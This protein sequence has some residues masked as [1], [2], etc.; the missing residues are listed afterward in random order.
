[1]TDTKII[2]L[3]LPQFHR[4]P[5]NDEFWGEGFTDW[6]SVKNAKPLYEGHNQPR[7]PLNNNYYDLS[8]KENVAWQAKL[9]RKYGIYG[10]GVYHY[11]F[12]NNQNLLT[13]PAEIMRDNDDID[14]NYCF[15][16]DNISWKRTWSNVEGNDWAPIYDNISSD[17]KSK[18]LVSYI[19][20]DKKDWEKHYQW[21]LPFFK[22][23]RYIKLKN[24]LVYVIFHYSAEVKE[25]CKY[26]DSLAKK[27][28]FDGF[29]FIFRYD[30]TEKIPINENILTYEPAYGGWQIESLLGIIK[31]RLKRIFINKGILKVDYDNTWEK[32]ISLANKN[33]S[34]NIIHGAFV[35]FDDSPRRGFKARIVENSTPEKFAKY[36]SDLLSI[37]RS[38]NKEFIFLSAWNEWGEGMMLEPDTINGYAY[39][40][41]IKNSIEKTIKNENF[42]QPK[43]YTTS[44][45]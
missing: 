4:I 31:R 12:N 35:S 5:E 19:L 41:A 32:I 2:A 44:K 36:F 33:N 8:Q 45:R 30:K 26:W 23:K 43:S 42:I 20:G 10:F 1:M 6:V 27:D 40:E 17:N 14:I 37:S 38:Q 29:E 3:Y 9:A 39:L 13:S 25:M 11:W 7:V 21:L 18:Y 34:K 24:K 15:V 22:D 16:W 28:G